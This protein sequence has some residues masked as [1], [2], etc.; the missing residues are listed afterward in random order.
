MTRALPFA[1]GLTL[2]LLLLGGCQASRQS[3]LND[4][5]PPFV[6]R[7]LDLRQQD[8]QGRPAWELTSPEARY[9]IG[10]RIARAESPK[11]VIYANGKPLYRLQAD[12]G[13]VIS[14]G[15]AILL[16]GHLRVERL[17]QPAV[18][19]QAARARW[20]P[21]QK[22]LLVDRAPVVYDHQGRLRADRARFRF[23]A[24][25]LELLGSP[26]LDRWAKP[27][28]PLSSL[29]QDSPETTVQVSK[30][31]WKP[32]TGALEA[33]GPVLGQ[34]LVTGAPTGTLPQRLSAERLQ[35]NTQS[36]TYTL[37]GAVHFEDPAQADNLETR[38]VQLDLAAQSG[39]TELPFSL[40]HGA[41]KATGTGLKVLGNE[42]LAVIAAQCHV[43]QPGDLLKAQR[44]QWNWRSGAVEAQG[45]VLLQRQANRQ[46]SR[47]EHL[48]GIL[49]Q[50]GTITISAPGARV[51]SRFQV[52][53]RRP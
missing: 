24:D 42:S 41:L 26:R 11:G 19:I 47:A 32:S 1:A 28:N 43:E 37:L 13:T 22:L 52:P 4:E 46:I 10:R 14:D 5:T 7:S 51:M 18:L 48:E 27:F 50:A 15:Q 35:G 44:C 23:D 49:G 17:S 45:S 21:H 25:T 2:A 39:R 36:Q 53:Q 8:P 29:P 16:E 34:R 9:D 3:K 33:D 30:L 40:N 38:D 6:F 31:T 20:L 12:S